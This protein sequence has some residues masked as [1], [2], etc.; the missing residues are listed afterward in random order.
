MDRRAFMVRALGA[1]GI[2]AFLCGAALT[3]EY[4][5]IIWR[6]HEATEDEPPDRAG[7][8]YCFRPPVGLDRE[9]A[10]EQALFK[11][12][13][14]KRYFLCESVSASAPPCTVPASSFVIFDH[15]PTWRDVALVMD[16]AR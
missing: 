15:R 4:P 5:P 16:Q 14:V 6:D 1:T 11:K 3:P 7:Q 13:F 2:G 8:V 9:S 10:A 12:Q